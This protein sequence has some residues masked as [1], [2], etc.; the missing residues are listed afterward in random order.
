M[1]RAAM[2]LVWRERCKRKQQTTQYVGDACGALVPVTVTAHNSS[3]P[4]AEQSKPA[5][6]ALT[7]WLTAI[8]TQRPARITAFTI[9]LHTSYSM[10]RILSATIKSAHVCQLVPIAAVLAARS[11]GQDEDQR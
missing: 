4:R 3:N 9:S 11:V 6:T 5:V 8:L 2:E 7:I 1:V 10:M